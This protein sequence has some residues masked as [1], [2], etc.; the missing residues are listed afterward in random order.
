MEKKDIFTKILAILGTILIWLPILAP[1]VF[2]LGPLI[3]AGRLRFDYLMPAELFPVAL[4][5]GIS[6]FWAALRARSYHKPIGW[7]LL[8]AV[9]LLFGGQGLAVVTGM[10]SGETEPTPLLMTLVLGMIVIYALLLVAI[11]IGGILLIRDL[12][13]HPAH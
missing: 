13:K 8:I 1:F 2:A 5:G 7:G 12:F 11:G 4:L 9:I 3:R 6:L 10:A